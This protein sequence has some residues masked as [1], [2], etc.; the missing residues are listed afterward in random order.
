MVYIATVATNPY[1]YECMM[2]GLL[3][4][5]LGYTL[6][7]GGVDVKWNGWIT[8]MKT[9]SEILQK[10]AIEEPDEL[11]IC[12]DAYDTLPIR[13]ENEFKKEFEQFHTDIV[14]SAENHCGG[15][16]R[17]LKRYDTSNSKYKYVN[18]GLLAGKAKPLAK[19]WTYLYEKKYS[20]DQIGLSEYIDTNFDMNHIQLDSEAKLF[21]N[22]ALAFGYDDSNFLKNCK[23]VFV[24]HFPGLNFFSSQQINYKNV[25]EDQLKLNNLDHTV[26][27]RTPKAN[28]IYLLL[29]IFVLFLYSIICTYYILKK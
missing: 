21:F 14:V 24:I 23:N 19:L 13:K 18:A 22:S 15:N 9:Y 25:L 8:K 28:N 6:K 2:M 1:Q 27:L 3:A 16:C 7:I 11:V 12:S 17:P 10:I 5:K 29:L 26:N 20:D 4:K